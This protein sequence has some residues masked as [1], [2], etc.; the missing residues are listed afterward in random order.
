MKKKIDLNSPAVHELV[1]FEMQNTESV[2]EL[3]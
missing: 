1:P 2:K 3:N